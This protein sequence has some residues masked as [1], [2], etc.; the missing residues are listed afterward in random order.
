MG[1]IARCSAGK[2]EDDYNEDLLYQMFGINAELLI[3]H[4]WGIETC[5][6]KD[7]KAYRPSNHSCGIGQVLSEPYTYEKGK[8]I[9][10]EMCEQLSLKLIQNHVNAESITLNVGYDIS[11]MTTNYTLLRLLN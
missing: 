11:S 6:I 9:V 7:I 3:D 5:T 1:D 10:K 8:I 4:A 2:Y